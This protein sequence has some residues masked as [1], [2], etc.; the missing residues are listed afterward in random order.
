M[1]LLCGKVFSFFFLKK[2][3][4]GRGSRKSMM[5]Q[6]RKPKGKRENLENILLRAIVLRLSEKY[7][8][9]MSAV[10]CIRICTIEGIRPLKS[11]EYFSKNQVPKHIDIVRHLFEV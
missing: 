7:E 8:R 9:K 3:P 6:I 10:L 2:F 11:K 4:S 1:T 5:H